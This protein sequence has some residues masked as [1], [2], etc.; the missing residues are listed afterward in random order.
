MAHTRVHQAVTYDHQIPR[1]VVHP[2]PLVN[3]PTGVTRRRKY[4]PQSGSISLRPMRSHP[5]SRIGLLLV[6]STSIQTDSNREYCAPLS[7]TGHNESRSSA[8]FL[9]NLPPRCAVE[10]QYQEGSVTNAL[11]WKSNFTVIFVLVKEHPN[12]SRS[13]P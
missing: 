4:A 1:S 13:H 12:C 11:I 2:K 10:G 9:E 3:L 7:C 6:I 8:W 5:T